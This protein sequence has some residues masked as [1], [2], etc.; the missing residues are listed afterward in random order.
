MLEGTI[1]L[2]FIERFSSE[3]DQHSSLGAIQLWQLQRKAEIERRATP[4]VLDTLDANISDEQVTYP[5][6]AKDV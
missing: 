4:P 6:Q 5:M 2:S 1:P 3:R